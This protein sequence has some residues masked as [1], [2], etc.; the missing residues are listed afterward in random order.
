ML[1]DGGAP[2]EDWQNHPKSVKRDAYQSID[3][4][5][6]GRT[7]GTFEYDHARRVDPSDTCGDDVNGRTRGRRRYSATQVRAR[8]GARRPLHTQ[9]A[10][11]LTSSSLAPIPRRHVSV[12]IRRW[13]RGHSFRRAM[14]PFADSAGAVAE[15]MRTSRAS[16]RRL[17]WS[18]ESSL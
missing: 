17:R 12:C 16:S 4:R 10:F 8:K 11:I 1:N 3:R 2:R 18:M 13:R 15:K 6:H 9:S 5:T 14:V 7:D